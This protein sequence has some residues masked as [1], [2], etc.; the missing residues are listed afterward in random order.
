MTNIPSITDTKAMLAELTREI[1]ALTQEL[2]AMPEVGALFH[3]LPV[4]TY[5]H[6]SAQIEVEAHEGKDAL[7]L[8]L[9]AYRQLHREDN[10]DPVTSVRYPGVIFC[11]T[12]PM[13]R[14]ARINSLKDDLSALISSMKGRPRATFMR[15]ALPNISSH[16]L[17]RHIPIITDEREVHRL[18]FT[19]TGNT[20]LTRSLSYEQAIESCNRRSSTG[21]INPR[22]LELLTRAEGALYERRLIA[23]HPRLNITFVSE[24]E[25]SLN[26]TM[27]PANLPILVQVTDKRPII[28][29]LFDYEEVERKPRSDRKRL[30][31]LLPHFDIYEEIDH[32][33]HA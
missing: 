9:D 22:D 25:G 16:H 11:P 27:I 24:V 4:M 6:R 20:P 7:A 28:T 15:Q 26:N 31:P 33:C 12:L 21:E 10:Q 29:P 5:A 3:R 13:A 17:T 23:P 2:A 14:V 30:H 8:C 18:S 1:Q 32:D 19:W